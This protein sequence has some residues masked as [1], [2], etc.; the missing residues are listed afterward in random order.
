MTTGFAQVTGGQLY[1][2]IDGD[3]PPVVLI[4]AG[5]WDSR[6]WDQQMKDFA[7]RHTVVR[8]DQR[9]FGRSDRFDEQFSERQDLAEL[10][11]HVGL[12]AASLVGASVGGAV[13]IDF[14]LEHPESVEA[15]VLVAAGLGGDSTEDDQGMQ[16]VFKEVQ[17][18]VAAGDLEQATDL[19]LQI[20][21][22]LRTDPEVDRRIREVAQDNRHANTLPWKLLHRLEPPAAGRLGEIR[23][24]TL[25]MVGDQDAP[26]M[27]TIADNIANGIP[28]SR[29]Y[30]VE[31]ADHLPNM[32]KPEEFNRVVLSFLGEVAGRSSL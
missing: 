18:A 23:A 1:F 12:P 8:Y 16:R 15:L 5:L 11:A 30:I 26:V 17:I 31:G 27:A 29:R 13:A 20:W 14:A 22:P 2:E 3:G 25:V 28:D 4:H 32:R 21:A 10:L 6:I 7:E 24:P 19:E 9:G